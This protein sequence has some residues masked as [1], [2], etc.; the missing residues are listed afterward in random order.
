MLNYYYKGVIIIKKRKVFIIAILLLLLVGFGEKGTISTEVKK[1]SSQNSVDSFTDVS[2][3]QW[4][5]EAISEAY[6][7]GLIAGYNPTKFGPNDKITRGQLVTIIYRMA[8]SPSTIAYSNKFSDVNDSQYYGNAVKWATAKDIIHGY[9][10]DKNK[11]GPNDPIVRQD[12]AIILNNYARY[13][14]YNYSTSTSLTSFSD[15]KKVE[16]SYSEQAL[17]WAV[18]LGIMNGKN[19]NNKKYIEPGSNTTRAEAAAMMINYVLVLEETEIGTIHFDKDS[20]YCEA[21][22]TFNTKITALG[23]EST[24]GPT[25]KS[26]KTSD[27]SIATIEKHPTLSVNCINC[28][29]VQVTC[30]KAGEVTLSATSSIGAT[31]TSS[32]EVTE[33]IGSIDFDHDSYTCKEGETINTKITAL[34]TPSVIAPTVDS[35]TSSDTSVATIEKHPTLAV[36]CINCKAVQIS[37]KKAGSS[38]LTATSSLG[39]VNTA[40]VTVVKDV[41]SISYAEEEY[42]CSPGES[43]T[44][45]VT[46]MPG[47]SSISNFY[48]DDT[49][50]ASVIDSPGVQ[51]KCINCR[52]VQVTCHAAGTTTIW[53]ESSRGARGGSQV[54]VRNP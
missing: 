39:A 47:T 20:Y 6:S 52:N 25:V 33:G 53:A 17:K 42:S 31:T 30:K 21:G 13:K 34:G 18:S 48:S 38:T 4:Y 12:F 7:R 23:T 2:K 32:V 41:G 3:K 45:Q 14:H 44:T 36:N 10:T 35:Y 19:I 11:F 8:G 27:T 5:Y 16:G 49:S 50:I 51:P 22:K 29:L 28:T 43:F 40:K 37:C 26:F 24:P 9:G 54:R 15:Y 46:S 1:Y